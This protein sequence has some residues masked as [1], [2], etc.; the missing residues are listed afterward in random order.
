MPSHI[1]QWLR[2][3]FKADPIDE[4]RS[5]SAFH[6][7]LHKDTCQLLDSE[8]N[9][10]QPNSLFFTKLPLELRCHILELAFGGKRGGK[11]H[12]RT[13]MI[14]KNRGFARTPDVREAIR[15]RR[16]YSVRY[17]DRFIGVLGWLLS[18]Q[19]AYF[20]GIDVLYRTNT[21][22]IMDHNDVPRVKKEVTLSGIEA[23]RHL[24]ILVIR[25]TNVDLGWQN[26]KETMSSLHD[27]AQLLE[28]ECIVDLGMPCIG[29]EGGEG[30]AEDRLGV[31][32]LGPAD[33]LVSAL[34]K[35]DYLKLTLRSSVQSF[36]YNWVSNT[37][38]E[39]PP[40]ASG[41]HIYGLRWHH[42][43]IGYPEP[44]QPVNSEEVEWGT[45]RFDPQCFFRVVPLEGG[46]ERKRGYWVGWRMLDS[47]IT[48]Y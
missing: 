22:S 31:N 35:L 8:P 3:A 6:R 4:G 13:D 10:S 25:V 24:R 43:I 7:F 26:Y 18:C 40:T 21:F 12:F 37:S 28:M 11:V 41:K 44:F 32:V 5:R 42:A 17:E 39:P 34:P 14:I 47:P 19:Q 16:I 9:G 36:L 27:F 33:A 23:M 45:S 1:L 38:P 48:E 20:E 46:D 29:Q 15:G 30:T 2:Y